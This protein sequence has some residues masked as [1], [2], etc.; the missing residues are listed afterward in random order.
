[1]TRPQKNE[2]QTWMLRHKV[3]FFFFLQQVHAWADFCCGALQQLG[4]LLTLE[5]T[6]MVYV[7]K[8][9]MLQR[10]ERV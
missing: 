6:L 8:R 3:V 5:I 7:V 4:I 1:M 9:S 2:E 10:R